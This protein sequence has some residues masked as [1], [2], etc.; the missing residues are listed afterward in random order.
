MLKKLLRSL[1]PQRSVS[2]D[3]KPIAPFIAIGDIHGRLDLLS[4]LLSE[5]PK[6]QIV[7][8]GDY[9]D[10]GDDSAGVLRLL[11]TRPDLICLSGNHEELMLKFI[12]AP[13]THGSHWLRYGG[14][15]TLA[16]YGI[17]GMTETS[18]PEA[19]SEARDALLSAMGEDM[20]NWLRAR[21][22]HWQSGNVAVVHAGA[23]PKIP[24]TEQ[25][26]RTL[27]WGHPDFRKSPRNDGVLVV[28]GHTIVDAPQ[29]TNGRISID[30]G[31]YATGR[32]S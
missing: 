13:Q 32:L 12:D 6:V 4:K 7:L 30:T 17:A 31:A 16:S 24:V 18:S 14:L 26:Y 1:T 5:A 3:A 19:M 9:V 29:N 8:V 23:D 27:H 28:H 22:T 20:L 10:R 11:S 2:F 25:S 21:P 15:Q